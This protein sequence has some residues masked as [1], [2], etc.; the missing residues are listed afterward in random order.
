[1][2]K[3]A[4]IHLEIP[5]EDRDATARFYREVF[6][7]SFTHVDESMSYPYTLF[8]TDNIGGGY[9]QV[10]ELQPGDVIVYVES[11][12]IEAD[13]RKIE[14]LGGKTV[15]PRTEITDVGW[16]A[17]FSDPTGNKLALFREERK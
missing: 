5:A 4:I 3:R 7:W 15:V 11:A 16:F 8:M 10:G 12:D 14:E 9:A 13:L 6:G 1:M 17:I 2:G